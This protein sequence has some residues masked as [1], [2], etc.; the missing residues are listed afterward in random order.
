MRARISF[1]F[2]EI[3]ADLFSANFGKGFDAIG[4]RFFLSFCH[5]IIAFVLVVVQYFL[6]SIENLFVFQISFFLV[7]WSDILFL[8]SRVHSRMAINIYSLATS[9]FYI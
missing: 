6:F 8:R 2:V 5:S 7:R 1:V 9:L 4:G 3:M